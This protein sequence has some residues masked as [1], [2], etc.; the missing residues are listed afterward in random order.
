MF[1]RISWTLGSSPR[2]TLNIICL[3]G[4]KVLLPRAP[5]RNQH[6]GLNPPYVDCWRS[7]GAQALQRA[8]LRGLEVLFPFSVW[9]P[10]MAGVPGKRA[11]PATAARK[12]SPPP[13]PSPQKGE[14][15]KRTPV[16]RSWRPPTAP[17][18]PP[19]K[20]K[21]GSAGQLFDFRQVGVK[22]SN[23]GNSALAFDIGRRSGAATIANQGDQPSADPQLV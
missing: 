16:G 9:T 13:K 12:K 2:V 3:A 21:P 1:C 19:L 17:L 8:A 5:Y 14:D 11:Q 20:G 6:D 22:G 23:S 7:G 18:K 15:L 4:V 10:P